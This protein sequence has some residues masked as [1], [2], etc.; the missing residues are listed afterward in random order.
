MDNSEKLDLST[1]LKAREVF[2]KFR[3]DMINDRD[4]AG[5][6]KAFEFSYE[7]SW[8][9]MKRVLAMRDLE[10]G[11]PKDTFRKAALE[12]LIDDPELWFE[13]QKNRNL[14]SYTY[15]E[16]NLELIIS[17]F[18]TFSSEMNILIQRLKALT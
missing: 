10:T 9:Y 1:L 11:S 18:D 12:K 5:A 16:A 17:I 3:Q 2:E 7:L 6:V 13:F 14:T 4:K 15:N 8:K